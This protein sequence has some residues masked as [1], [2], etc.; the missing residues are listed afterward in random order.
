MKVVIYGLAKDEAGNVEQFMQLAGQA[1]AVYILDTGSTDGTPELLTQHGAHVA[2]FNYGSEFRFDHARNAS[3]ALVPP[4]PDTICLY[5]DLDERLDRDWRSKLEQ[6]YDPD[7]EEYQ[8]YWYENQGN[9]ITFSNIRA[10]SRTTHTWIYPVHEVL[11]SK[12]TVRSVHTGIY[13]T[14]EPQPKVRNYLPLLLTAYQESPKDPRVLHYLGREY[15]YL[16]TQNSALYEQALLMF[17]KY[18]D[19]SPS[20]LWAPELSQ[21]LN[22]CAH[23]YKQLGQY[24][25]AEQYYLKS[26][27]AFPTTR[28]PYLE[29][30]RYYFDCQELESCLGMIH[31]A[32][33]ITK[34]PDSYLYYN[35]ADWRSAPYLLASQVYIQLNL[36]DKAKEYFDQAFEYMPPTPEL[37]VTYYNAFGTLPTGLGLVLDKAMPSSQEAT[38]S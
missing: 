2:T 12:H 5:L 25:Q 21:V 18:I 9:P 27:A 24:W 35:Y 36:G 10:H 11:T 15:M 3:L 31:T 29:L 13:V 16:G 22:Y 7:V 19:R 38:D 30:A 33:R 6:V 14:H 34:V 17:H 4:E 37:I 1:D 26:I 8:F 32:L 20:T 28:E 23:C